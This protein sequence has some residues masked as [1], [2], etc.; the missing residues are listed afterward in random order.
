M[1]M[2]GGHNH[3][4]SVYGAPLYGGRAKAAPSA[5]LLRELHALLLAQQRNYWSTHQQVAG[6]NYYG[7]HLLFER[8][9]SG[10]TDQIDGLAERMVALFG[11]EIVD[12]VDVA[13][14]TTA[15]LER[16]SKTRDPI[17][18]ALL[19]ETDAQGQFRAV[20]DGLKAAGT[21]SLGMDDF[22]MGLASE[23]DQNTYLLQQRAS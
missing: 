20:Y 22:L 4:Y 16:W 2:H 8:L 3:P 6:P 18:R 10:L 7:D 17:R 15:W 23:H 9:Y 19:S 12:N 5:E 1:S 21:L 11:P 13:R 14:R